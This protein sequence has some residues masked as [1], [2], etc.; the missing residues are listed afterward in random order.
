M[1]HAV[2]IGGGVGGLAA[3]LALQRRGWTVTVCERAPSLD[4]VGAGLAVAANALKAL[5]VL[6]VGDAVRELSA[7]RGQAGIRRR[8]G[9]W[10]VRVCAE[11]AAA[12]HGDPPVPLTRAALV[13]LL[14]ERLTPGTLRPG[15]TVHSA[16]PDS[17]RV[18]TSAGDLD[19][20]LVVAAD[21]IHSAIRRAL[22]PD[23][24]GPAYAGVTSWRMLVPRDGLPCPA[25][26]SWGA[27]RV[28]GVL[29]LA[30][31][32]VY[33]YGTDTVPAGG[34]SA[35]ERAELL[36]LF[37]DWHDPIPRLL[38][39]ADPARILR[40]DVY[41]LSRPLPAFHRGRIALLGDAAH[42]MTPYLGQGACQAV[43]D[44]VV[45]AHLADRPDGP[46]AYTAARLPRTTRIV[47]RSA[48]VC[49]ATKARHPLAVRLRDTAMALGGRLDPDLLLTATDGILGWRPPT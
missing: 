31:D 18:T 25:A 47:R 38:E 34:R 41:S 3:A 43:E 14:A 13:G 2:V 24:P 35:D 29:P 5:D 37:G 44:A 20:D 11:R 33:C 45:L 26:E 9:R 30:G 32:L 6:G 8:D 48:S 22:F 36:R 12:R 16:D 23:H 39:A 42:A 40:T 10:L 46:A 49:R 7:V 28:F 17:G 27:G 15:T 19:A 21:G 1:S 4:P